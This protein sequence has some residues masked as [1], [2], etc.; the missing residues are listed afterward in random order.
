M[1]AEYGRHRR[2]AALVKRQLALLLQREPIS[3]RALLTVSAVTVSADLATARVYISCLV[4]EP[5]QRERL[6]EELN[7]QAAHYRRLLSGALALR[8]VP[9]LYFAY[10]RPLEDAR[11]VNELLDS[12]PEA[13]E[14]E[15]NPGK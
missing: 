9:K 14:S 6:V 13:R 7:G 11:R 4:D 8:G 3:P 1:P 2:V 5:S 15:E 10:D 12:L